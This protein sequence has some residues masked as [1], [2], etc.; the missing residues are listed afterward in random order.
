MKNKKTTF[1]GS[2]M[3]NPVPVVVVTSKDKKGISNAFTV[4]WIGT[5]C[6][7][8][9]MLSISIRPERA[10]YDMIKESGEFIVNIPSEK[11]VAETD[12]CGVKS[13]T[14]VDKIKEMGFTMISGDE[15]KVDY[16][17]E[18]PINIECKVNQIIKLGC[19]DLFIANVLKTHIDSTLIDD[20]G[21]ISFDKANLLSYCHG[22]YYP[23]G[24]KPIGKFGYSIVKNKKIKAEYDKKY[25]KFSGFNKVKKG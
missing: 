16:I 24:K 3:L 25:G 9:P 8:P 13:L 20:T 11:Y 17:Q 15:V 6:S 23:I 22:E 14:Q 21:K 10:S 4:A 5:V 1:Q 18:F 7:K 19:H 2:V 12:Y